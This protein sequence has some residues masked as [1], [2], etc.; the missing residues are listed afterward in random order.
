MAPNIVQ[1]LITKK[2]WVSIRDITDLTGQKHLAIV[3]VYLPE[4]KE[5]ELNEGVVTFVER[6]GIDFYFTL[7]ILVLKRTKYRHYDKS[8]KSYINSWLFWNFHPRHLGSQFRDY[9]LDYL[10]C[11]YATHCDFNAYFC[12]NLGSFL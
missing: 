6:F 4:L 10:L 1:L 8:K 11:K 2:R 12:L 3:Q 5:A 7:L 9:R